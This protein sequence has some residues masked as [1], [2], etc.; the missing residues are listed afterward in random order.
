VY[1]LLFIKAGF[2]YGRFS[3]TASSDSSNHSGQS[4][5]ARVSLFQSAIFSYGM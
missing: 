2:E 3:R 4:G 5:N 1:C